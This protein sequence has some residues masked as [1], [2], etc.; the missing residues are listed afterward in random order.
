M[1]KKDQKALS[2]LVKEYSPSELLGALVSALREHR[3]SLVDLGIKDQ[4]REYSEVAEL[5]SEIHLVL[6]EDE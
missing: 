5:L 4:V 1:L 2:V 6:I 3:D